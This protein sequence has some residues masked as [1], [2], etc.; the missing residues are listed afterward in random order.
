MIKNNKKIILASASPRRRELL[1][2]IGMEFQVLPSGAE[3]K[4]GNCSPSEMVKELSHLKALD[5]FQ[6]LSGGEQAQSLVIGA[7]TVVAL[8]N[9]IMG[10]PG[11]KENAVKML[12]DLQGRTHQVY[13]GVTLIWQEDKSMVQREISFYEETS[14]TM[15]P[16]TPEE[17][18]AY[19]ATGEPMDKAGA[20]GIQGKCAAYIKGISGDYNNVVGLPIGRLYQEMKKI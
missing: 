9:N 12:S 15:F 18:E 14:V 3:E 6:K 10:K 4:T 8:D 17:I 11:N 1:A 16:M 19:V 20:Y 7:D 13:T 5:I 2:Q